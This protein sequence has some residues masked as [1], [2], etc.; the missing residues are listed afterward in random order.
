[1][2]I[3][4]NSNE[5]VGK[6][7]MNC[8]SFPYNINMPL[9]S[10]PIWIEELTVLIKILRNGGLFAYYH[11]IGIGAANVGV[12]GFAGIALA[13]LRTPIREVHHMSVLVND[14]KKTNHC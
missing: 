12:G 10:N 2:P 7:E 6:S 14:Q 11:E 3:F 13:A 1:M 5:M 9:N 4:Q 8:I